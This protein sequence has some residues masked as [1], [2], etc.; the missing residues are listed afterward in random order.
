MSQRPV[1]VL[2]S[3]TEAIDGGKTATLLRKGPLL[4]APSGL[5]PT[6]AVSIT[7]CDAETAALLVL[8]REFVID[9]KPLST[10]R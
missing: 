8:G 9:I 10:V 5:V 3:V 1:Y 7:A 6:A 4:D 2:S